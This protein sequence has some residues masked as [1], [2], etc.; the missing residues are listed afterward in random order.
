MLAPLE[1]RALV[2][3]W[4]EDLRLSKV[5]QPTISAQ[6][7]AL[8]TAAFRRLRRQRVG[9]PASHILLAVVS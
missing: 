6:K 1:H 9:P 8:A 3:R 7:V 5:L 2:A 4:R